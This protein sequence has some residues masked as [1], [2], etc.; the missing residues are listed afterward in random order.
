MADANVAAVRLTLDGV[1]LADKIEPRFIDLSLSEKRD[2]SA[3]ELSLTLHNSDGKMALP[4]PGKVITLALGWTSGTD[5]T[6]GLVEKGRFTVDEVEATGPPDVIRITARSADLNGDY[7]KRRTQSWK[8]TTLGAVLGEIARRN[9]ITAQ[10]HPDLAG[11]P[12]TALDQHGK[13][14]MLLVKDLGSRYDAVATWKD[15]KLVFMP[16]G[17]ATTAGGK[18]LAAKTLTKRDGWSWRFTR[19]Q[20]DE[21]DGAEASWHDQDSGKKKTTSTGGTKRKRLKRAYA[22]EADAEQAAEAE[23]AKRKRGAYQFEYELAFADTALQPN[24]QVTLSGWN[25]TV[26]GIK[27]LLSSVD[28]SVAGGGGIKQRISLESA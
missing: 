15:R 4:E 16:V 25:T 6:L 20:R 28:T 12:I 2:G 27:W 1:D 7:R 11:K 8:D 3:D 17:S 24:Q 23:A 21:Y 5:V 19:A 22:S 14:D 13:S 10:V 18:T 9:S 26:D